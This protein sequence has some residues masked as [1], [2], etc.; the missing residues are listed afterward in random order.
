MEHIHKVHKLELK[1]RKLAKPSLSSLGHFPESQL[2]LNTQGAIKKNKQRTSKY[3]A[4]AV[5][6][7][8]YADLDKERKTQRSFLSFLLALFYGVHI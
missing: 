3:R 8:V 1:K 2:P 7:R 5:V 4:N 6:S